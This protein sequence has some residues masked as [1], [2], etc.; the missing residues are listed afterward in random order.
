LVAE[1][2]ICA[3]CGHPIPE[4]EVVAIMTFHVGCAPGELVGAWR[5]VA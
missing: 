2:V 5:R 3:E 4:G 1:P